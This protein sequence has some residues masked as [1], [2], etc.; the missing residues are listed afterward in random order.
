M[1]LSH[2]ES[3]FI[4]AKRVFGVQLVKGD[5]VGSELMND[6]TKGEAAPP[7]CGHVEDVDIVIAFGHGSAP[8]F[9]GFGA[10][11][12]RHDDEAAEAVLP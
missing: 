1:L 5:E 6:G 9:Q 12:Q 11:Q 3:Q 4:V 8:G 10:L 2:G 7:G